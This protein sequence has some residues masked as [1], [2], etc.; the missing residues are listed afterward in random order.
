MKSYIN[1]IFTGILCALLCLGCKSTKYVPEGDYL[2]TGSQ[3]K[4]QTDESKKYIKKLQ[5]DLQDQIKPKP[6]SRIFG[7]PLKLNLYSFVG[8]PK[9]QKGLKYSIRTKFGQAP[10]L[11]SAV[12][13]S[14][15]EQALLA[16]LYNNSFFDAEVTYT[17]EKDTQSRK[18]N[19]VYLIKTGKSYRIDS[20]TS[21]IPDTTIARIMAMDQ[22]QSR[23]KV[24][25]RYNLNRLK[26]ERARIDEELKNNGYYHFNPDYLVYEA[27]TSGAKSAVTMRLKLKRETPEKSLRRYMMSEVYV[28][29]DSAYASHHSDHLNDT[30]TIDRVTLALNKDFRPEPIAQ[31]VYLKDSSYYSRESQQQT[32]GRLMGMGLFKYADVEII[33]K[34]S[35]HLNAYIH[36]SPLP[37]KSIS[38]EV[39]VVSKSNNFIGPG[40]NLNFTNRNAF[41]GGEKLS[42][43]FHG[44]IE[45]QINGQFKGLY[46]YEL[47]PQLN[48]TVP[49]FIT[50]VRIKG[51]SLYTPNTIFSSSYTFLSRVNYFDMRSLQI[52]FGYKW[53]ESLPV[54]H[55]LRPINISFFN[56]S[57]ISES[58]NALLQK[59][60]ALQRRYENQLIAGITYSYTYN[61]Q[62]FPRRK[63]QFYFN[64]N[65]D[66][67]GNTLN[68]IND[69]GGGKANDIGTKTAFGVAY[70]QYAR[71]D[72]DLRNYIKVNRKSMFAARMIV[73]WGIPYGNSTALPFVKGFFS[74]GTSSLR[75][76]PVNSVGPGTYRLPDSLQSSYFIQQGGDIKLEWSAE[77]RFPIVSIIKGAFFLDAGNVWLYKNDDLIP[78]AQFKINKAFTQLAIGTGF[79]IRAD[80]NFFIIRLDLATPLRKPWLPDSE[81]WVIDDISL[82]SAAWRRQNIILNIAIGYP[83]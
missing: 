55:Y 40:M 13:P 23:I 10:V 6:N 76:F 20:Y 66:I 29:L 74:G 71:F 75:A 67:A 61:Q 11:F 77:Y 9:K 81:A 34:D 16:A 64:G 48:L 54:E 15:T 26:E 52:S 33:E 7:L 51:S 39:Q 49:R 8:I 56:L 22:D 69:I 36:L 72:V 78:G 68:L 60:P 38:V 46:T 47:G 44:S 17:I 58:F 70:A 14:F 28:V 31:Y 59:S 3:M 53:K 43:S 21:K 80:L 45:T 37:R 12:N 42:L 4:F 63:N 79:G 83:F 19:V 30:V 62:V 82:G 24:G 73:G 5:S 65:A 18:A 50:P 41:R 2:Y 35:T 27:D 32:V 57:N 1:I 25:R